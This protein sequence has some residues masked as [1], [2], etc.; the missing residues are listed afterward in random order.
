MLCARLI[1]L[2][3]FCVALDKYKF[4][5]LPQ[6]IINPN[7]I[8][9]THSLSSVPVYWLNDQSSSTSP[10]VAYQLEYGEVIDSVSDV[11]FDN[12]ISGIG[13]GYVG[14]SV[15]ILTI[16]ADTGE[17]IDGNDLYQLAFNFGD[18]GSNSPHIDRESN[19]ITRK[20]PAT[21]TSAELKAALEELENIGVVEVRRCDDAN[22]LGGMNSWVGG[23]DYNR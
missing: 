13:E 2:F 22:G 11:E 3:Q 1:L 14:N 12:V 5:P 10:I 17:T 21:A 23:C 6:P 7:H 9:T 19:T 15:Q 16:K 18:V 8:I 20:I 4:T